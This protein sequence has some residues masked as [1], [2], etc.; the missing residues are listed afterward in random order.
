MQGIFQQRADPYDAI[1]DQGPGS[2][3]PPSAVR[4]GPGS[5]LPPSAVEALEWNIKAAGISKTEARKKRL[6]ERM[7]PPQKGFW[8]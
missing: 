3:L 4:Q 1:T 2:G 5:G 7:N 6:M 8:A